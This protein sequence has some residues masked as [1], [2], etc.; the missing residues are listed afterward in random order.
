MCGTF[1]HASKTIKCCLRFE[2]DKYTES[3]MKLVEEECHSE[4][5]NNNKIVLKS[6]VVS[7]NYALN[8]SYPS[9]RLAVATL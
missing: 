1:K 7:P 2:S 8:L 5:N 9:T 4:N 6:H 3:R